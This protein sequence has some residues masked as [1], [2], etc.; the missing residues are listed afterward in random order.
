[1]GSQRS[2]AYELLTKLC[3]EQ[4]FTVAASTEASSDD[5][6][7]EVLSVYGYLLAD[8]VSYRNERELSTRDWGCRAASGFQHG[9]L[10]K[11]LPNDL[12]AQLDSV[13]S[14]AL[15]RYGNRVSGLKELAAVLPLL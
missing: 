14:D 11:M 9:E 2:S 3:A 12:K 6:R 5:E 4:I 7:T 1:M 10:H 15:S 13:V 8:A